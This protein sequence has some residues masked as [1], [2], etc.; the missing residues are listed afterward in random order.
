MSAGTK[1]TLVERWPLFVWFGI[2]GGCTYTMIIIIIIIIIIINI[3]IK[4]SNV[5]LAFLFL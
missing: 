4:N 2:V 3:I 1:V 5:L